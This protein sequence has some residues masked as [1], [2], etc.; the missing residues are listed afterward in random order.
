M[1]Y[2]ENIILIAKHLYMIF[3]NLFGHLKIKTHYTP[4]KCILYYCIFTVYN[5]KY[6]HATIL[7]IR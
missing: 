6:F 4:Y 5:A 3:F 2:I 7:I 1:T